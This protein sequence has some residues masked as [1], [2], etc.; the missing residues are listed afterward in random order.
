[1]SD[2]HVL[3]SSVQNKFARMC[4]DASALFRTATDREEIWNTYLESFPAAINPIYRTKREYD[5][6]CCRHFIRDFGNVVTLKNGV[7]TSIWEVDT[8]DPNFNQVCQAM[9][10]YV[11]S[12]PIQGVYH[13]REKTVGNSCDYSESDGHVIRYDHWYMNVPDK[14]LDRRGLSDGDYCGRTNELRNVFKRSLDEISMDS[15]DTVLELIAQNSL[16]RGLEWKKPIEQF[17]QFKKEYDLLPN[18]K[19]ELYAWEKAPVAGDVVGKIRNHSIGLLLTD[20]A[21]GVDL[22]TAVRKYEAIV[23]PA[24]YK[25]PKAIFTQ[26]MVEEAQKSIEEMGFTDSLPRRFATLDDITVNNILYSNKDAAKRISGASVFDAMKAE[27]KKPQTFDRAEEI[28]IEDFISKVLPTA[29]E[30]EVYLEGRHAKNMVSLIAPQH[31]DAKPMFKWNNGF[32]WAYTGN[33]T[34]SDIR[35]N[36]KNAGGK[37]DG[38][39][40]FSIQW[41]DGHEHD[42]N[43]LD[44]HCLEPN[45]NHIFFRSKNDYATTG[46]LD[47]DIIDPT[48]GKAAVEN[49]TWSNRSKMPDGEYLFYVHCFTNRGGHSGFR[50]E[51]EFDGELH[52]Y[53]YTNV[54]RQSEVV[55]VAKVTLRNG[56]FTVKD[57]LPASASSRDIW[58]VKTNQFVPV[59][60]IMYSPNYWD[61]QHGIG[62]KHYLFMLK[63]CVNPER[64]NGIFNEFLCNELMAH[65]RVMEALGSKLRVEDTDD[66]LSGVGFSSTQRNELVVRVTGQTKRVLKIKF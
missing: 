55:N 27:A 7:V 10:A 52:S 24:N 19:K 61:D 20:I 2:F 38:V 42:G 53:D 17:R 60:T 46:N 12:K 4:E 51:I 13:A 8:N 41:N 58:G 28:G 65:K 29:Q 45:G 56:V 6:S 23:A 57:L 11:K 9:T 37:V 40:R 14:F 39:L 48:Y 66:Q 49:I 25:R 18:N 50:A 33:M 15:V 31:K 63:D 35:Q 64:P 30:V 62:N 36:V 21:E 44:A 5:C 1:M 54:M 47:I 59:S 43:D 16:Y 22:D 32:S 34:D 3:L 26:K